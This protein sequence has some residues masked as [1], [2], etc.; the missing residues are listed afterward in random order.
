MPWWRFYFHGRVGSPTGGEPSERTLR[1]GRRDIPHG[2]WKKK[3]PHHVKTRGSRPL[4]VDRRNACPYCRHIPLSFFVYFSTNSRPCQEVFCVFLLITFCLLL[5]CPR[6]S[7]ARPD[8]I[9]YS[10]TIRC[11]SGFSWIIPPERRKRRNKGRFLRK[12]ALLQQTHEAFIII[13]I[14]GGVLNQNASA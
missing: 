5:P 9:S 1:R 10:P 4:S 11:Y 7:Y 6:I 13:N 2:E 12:S 3:R 14:C 8:G